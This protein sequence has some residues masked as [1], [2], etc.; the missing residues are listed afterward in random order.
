MDPAAY[1]APL[2]ISFGQRHVAPL[3]P[4]FFATLSLVRDLLCF[5]GVQSSP[6]MMHTL[7]ASLLAMVSANTF[8]SDCPAGASQSAP[9]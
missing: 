8:M 2:P 1:P 9:K 7:L 5:S 6:L 3:L 4:E